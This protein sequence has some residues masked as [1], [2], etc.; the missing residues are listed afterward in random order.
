MYFMTIYQDIYSVIL[1][2]KFGQLGFFMYNF[3]GYREI[4]TK[5]PTNWQTQQYYNN[6]FLKFISIF[7]DYV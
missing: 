4:V 2:I 5:L 6:V 1:R 7:Y 3:R